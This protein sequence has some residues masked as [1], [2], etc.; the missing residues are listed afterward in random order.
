MATPASDVFRTPASGE[1]LY[2]ERRIVRVKLINV[3]PPVAQRV[4]KTSAFCA[5]RWRPRV[6]TAIHAC[7]A[8]A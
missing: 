3:K 7:A 4:E 2:L 5:A 6:A 1:I 8:E